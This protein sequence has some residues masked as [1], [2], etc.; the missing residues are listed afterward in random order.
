MN[1]TAITIRSV[2]IA[3]CAFGILW[4]L[5]AIVL[6]VQMSIFGNTSMLGQN[7]FNVFQNALIFIY[8]LVIYRQE[9]KLVELIIKPQQS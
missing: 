2:A 8:G 3:T 5:Q 4:T 9:P 1:I 7:A 6:T